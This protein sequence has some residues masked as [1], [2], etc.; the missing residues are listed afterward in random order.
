MRPVIL[1]AEVI[2]VRSIIVHEQVNTP[3]CGSSRC[4]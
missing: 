3:I 2:S 1:N 4:E